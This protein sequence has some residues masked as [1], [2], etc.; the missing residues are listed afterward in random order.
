MQ[1]KEIEQMA[2]EFSKKYVFEHKET[3]IESYTAGINRAKYVIEQLETA[4]EVCNQERKKY[5]DELD[6]TN[7]AYSKLEKEYQSLLGASSLLI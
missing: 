2:I 6:S 1:N 7:A 3:A 5:R 4:L